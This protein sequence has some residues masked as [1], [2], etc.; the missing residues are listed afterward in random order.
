[1]ADF[2]LFPVSSRCRI[3][4]AFHLD[5]FVEQLK[6][7]FVNYAFMVIFQFF[8]FSYACPMSFE[9]LFVHTDII[10][11]YLLKLVV[12]Y[13]FDLVSVAVVLAEKCNSSVANFVTSI[14][15]ANL[16]IFRS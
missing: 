10:W 4:A 12:F 2:L 7:F 5:V 14:M 16:L 9:Y 13:R 3:S 6:H 1:V 15:Q 11:V 8:S